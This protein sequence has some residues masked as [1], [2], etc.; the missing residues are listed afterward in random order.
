MIGAPTSDRASGVPEGLSG[1]ALS[2]RPG[3][4]RRRG[5]G[6]GPGGKR[7]ASCDTLAHFCVMP[8]Q[9]CAIEHHARRNERRAI[10]VCGVDQG[11]W[12]L[13]GFFNHRSGNL[14]DGGKGLARRRGAAAKLRRTGSCSVRKGVGRRE[15][16]ALRRVAVVVEAAGEAEG[17]QHVQDLLDI[18]ARRTLEPA[19]KVLDMRWFRLRRA[20]RP[21]SRVRQGFFNRRSC[22]LPDGGKGLARRQGAAA[23]LRRALAGRIG[24][25]MA[26]VALARELAV[27]LQIHFGNRNWSW[28]R[29]IHSGP[30]CGCSTL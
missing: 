19:G 24:M 2:R 12:A 26:R 20:R 15:A 30:Y 6:L 11:F 22:N 16:L 7:P 8:P 5:R 14:P 28:K 4:S 3:T 18:V 29:M 27:M 25:K 9:I 21:T 1:A 17:D 23:K 13:Q 10:A